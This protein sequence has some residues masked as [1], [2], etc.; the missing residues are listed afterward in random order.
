M[1]L[2]VGSDPLVSGHAENP[3]PPQAAA[4]PR[5]ELGPTCAHHMDRQKMNLEFS[6]S[7]SGYGE[8]NMPPQEQG[9]SLSQPKAS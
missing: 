7:N 9:I 8:G 6:T 1:Q 3:R 4:L 2:Q 5:P